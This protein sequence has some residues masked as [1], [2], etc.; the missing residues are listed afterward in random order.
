LTWAVYY[1]HL[2]VCIWLV[3][4][5]ASIHGSN[6]SQ[7]PICQPNISNRR[8]VSNGDN[9]LHDSPLLMAVQRNNVHLVQWL[10]DHGADVNS[11]S[12]DVELHQSALHLAAYHAH[13]EVV[14]TLLAAGADIHAENVQAKRAANIA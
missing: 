5:G 6:N 14:A 8:Y 12:L 1:G 7:P 3:E 4:H 9:S 10:L 2:A 11:I 13:C